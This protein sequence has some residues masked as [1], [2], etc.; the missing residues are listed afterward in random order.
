MRLEDVEAVFE[1]PDPNQSFIAYVQQTLRH[2]LDPVGRY[3]TVWLANDAANTHSFT[4]DQMRKYANVCETP[5]SQEVLERSV[6]QLEAT[7]VVRQRKRGIYEFSVPDYP[8]ILNR[9]GDTQLLDNLE[10]EI[11]QTL[12]NG[13]A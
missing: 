5:I 12:G 13:D 4:M 7:N 11:A 8:N 6:E 2:N 1:D 3:V 10:I 9:M